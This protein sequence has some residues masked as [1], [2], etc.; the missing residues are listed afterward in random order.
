[1]CNF[2]EDPHDLRQFALGLGFD[3][4]DW[5]F[6]RD[7]LPR[8]PR[9]T[10]A[11]ID[12]IASLSPLEIRY[13]CFVKNADLGDVDDRQA[14]DAMSEFRY[15]CEVVSAVGGRVAT[16]HIGLGLDSTEHLSWDRTVERLGELV[17]FAESR[18]VR[19]CLENLAWGWTSRPRLFEKLLRKSGCWGTLDIGHARVSPSIASQG[20]DVADFVAPH[21]LR[22][23]NA[24]I[25]HEETEDGHTAARSIGDIEERL[26]ILEQLYQCD[27]WVLELREETALLETLATVREFLASRPYC[28]SETFP[29]TLADTPGKPERA[30]VHV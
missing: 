21:P 19:L 17:T 4:I 18:G 29:R 7:S 11:L 28:G 5:T 8:T 20:Y 1:M 23:L 3:G 9:E 24:H 2:I 25:Y 12:T 6:T 13:H 14:E 26:F 15:L 22:F 27:W 10:K 30:D 16:I